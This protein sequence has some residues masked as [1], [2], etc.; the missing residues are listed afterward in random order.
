MKK[1][2]IM[3]IVLSVVGYIFL[4]RNKIEEVKKDKKSYKIDTVK[5]DTFEVYVSA[6]GIV[7]PN[8]EV[9]VKSKA[10]GEIVYFPVQEGDF[11]KKGTL[12]IKL[13]PTNEERK[14]KEAQAV[15][16]EALAKLESAKSSLDYEKITYKTNLQSIGYSIRS[17][18]VEILDIKKKLKRKEE[19]FRENLL[20]LEELET[21]KTDLSTAR[22]NLDKLFTDSE[23]AAIGIE[24]IRMKESD[25][26]IVQSAVIKARISLQDAEERLKETKI[27]AS[28]DGVVLTR[29]V[30]VGQIISS[31]ISN[32]G[33]GTLLCTMA[34]LSKL[35]IEADVDEADIGKVQIRQKA[36]ITVESFQGKNFF[37]T[38]SWISPQGKED[39]NVTV[40]QVRIEVD[41]EGTELLLSR[42]TANVNIL[43]LR[44]E[45]TLVVPAE[46]VRDRDGEFFVASPTL[47]DSVV[48]VPVVPG[49]TDGVRTELISGPPDKTKVIVSGITGMSIQSG[50]G[51]NQQNL[52]RG[53]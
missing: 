28:M 17:E 42:M 3:I 25:I 33:G 52:R 4:S 15:L 31:G 5:Y 19:L 48:W 11:V 51:K 21:W 9:E 32:V 34:D 10:S 39:N 23:A 7:K 8:Y 36:R 50:P 13:D 16:Y 6:T 47:G 40:F 41:K 18:K 29:N 43:V 46:A 44:K 14:L 30:E 38:V 27:Y 37:G 45:N 49:A 26:K 20:S 12:I 53:M 2:L 22:A 35:F 1:W 24:K